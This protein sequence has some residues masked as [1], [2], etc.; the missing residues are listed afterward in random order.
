MTP[1][2]VVSCAYAAKP[3]PVR[4]M[5]TGGRQRGIPPGHRL[6]GPARAMATV[7]LAGRGSA[8]MRPV[9]QGLRIRD[10]NFNPNHGLRPQAMS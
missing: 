6:H 10:L 2:G 1:A 5:R 4:G 7:S 3:V 9:C 8:V